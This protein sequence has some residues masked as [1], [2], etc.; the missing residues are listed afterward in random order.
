VQAR[1]GSSEKATLFV[2]E[3]LG[4][5]NRVQYNQNNSISALAGEQTGF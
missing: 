1:L 2:R 5:V 4:A 3:F